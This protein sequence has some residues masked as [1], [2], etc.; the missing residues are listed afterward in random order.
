MI[1]FL[2]KRRDAFG[3]FIYRH[4]AEAER[5]IFSAFLYFC[6]KNPILYG[7]LANK[8]KKARKPN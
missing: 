3:D 7:F 4:C 5:K 2:Y 1:S 6:L 8:A